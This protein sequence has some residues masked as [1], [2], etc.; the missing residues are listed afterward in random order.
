MFMKTFLQTIS[1]KKWLIPIPLL[2]LLVLFAG[3]ASGQLPDCASGNSMYVIYN[4]SLS[5]NVKS[6]IRPVSYATGA[7]G[8]LMGGTGY[9]I[10]KTISGT[11]YYG[12]SS[13]AVDPLSQRFFVNTTM[14]FAGGPKDFIAINTLAATTAVIATT[15]SALTA[16]VP[17]AGGLD[18]YFFV[19]MGVSV[20]GTGY[21]IGVSRDT[22]AT[23]PATCNPLISFTACGTAACSTIKLLGF[24]PPGVLTDNWKIYNGDLAFNSTGDLYYLSIGF[25]QVNGNSRYTDLRLFKIL[26]TDIPSTAGVGIIPMSFVADYNSLD[27]TVLNGLAFDPL[28]KMYIS[29]RRYAGPQNLPLPKFTNELYVSGSAGSA[30]LIPGFGPKPASMIAA[31]LASC[32]FPLAVLAV[33]ENKLFGNYANG[34]IHLSW[35]VNN[36]T[37]VDYFE[38]QSSDN[39]SDFTTIARV[40]TKNTSQGTQTYTFDGAESGFGIAR[41]YRVRQVMVQNARYYSNVLKINFSN[42]IQSVSKA[43]PNPFNSSITTN[44]EL[45]TE[46]NIAMRLL[47]N[48]GKLVSL[49]NFQGN[50]GM[51]KLSLDNLTALRPGLYIL[52]TVVNEETIR[53]KIIKQ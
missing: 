22:T 33:N 36:N 47:D 51:N 7:V 34:N 3:N 15:P 45:R 12:S 19:K 1:I 32:Y 10:K 39:G 52:E 40:S 53:E 46:A 4:D 21:A 43:M 44:V 37:A 27:S 20:G 11:S 13:L 18:N 5:G 35:E 14:S 31:D 16:N 50:R 2:L 28:G 25:H 48:S 24:L 8:A 49:K 9:L 30:T 26:A 42:K 38:I 41:Y 29:T 23:T 6:E 17:I